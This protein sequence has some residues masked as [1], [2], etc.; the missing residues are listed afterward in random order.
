VAN[1]GLV[2]VPVEV[3]V[4]VADQGFPGM[5]V[6]GLASKAVEESRERVKTAIVNSGM[7]FPPKKITVNLAPADLPKDGAAYDLPIA[8]GILAAS[9]QI[10]D[11]QLEVLKKSLFYGELSLEGTLRSTKGVLL[12]GLYATT[13]PL[14][15]SPVSGEGGFD[16]ERKRLKTEIYV[17]IE[18]AN[19]AAVVEGISVFPVRNLKELMD[20]LSG[21][22]MI[23]PLKYIDSEKVISDASAEFDLSEVAGQEMA[24][25]ALT[26]AAAGGHNLIMWGPPGT[27]KTMLARAMPGILPPLLP[28]EALEVTRVYSVAGLLES[29][30]SLIRRRPFRSPHHGVSAAGM[31]G[32]GSN[33]LPG[34]V[35][36]AHLGV[37]FLDE[38]AEFPRGVLESL[39]QPME[40]GEVEIVRASAHVSYPASFTLVAAVNPCPCGYLGHPRREC[41]CG[42]KQIRKY[43]AKM[44]GPIL[45][46]IDLHVQ[47]PAVEVGKLEQ[48]SRAAGEQ[49]TSVA[50]R[51]RVMNARK[52][53]GERFKDAGIYTN[54]QMK[55]R[56][57]KQFCRLDGDSERL[58]RLA[59]EKYDLS[60]RAYFRLIKVARTIADLEGSE[61]I[62]VSHMAE[63]LQ[64]RQ[65]G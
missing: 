2:S 47:V 34:E 49:E 13:S 15:P 44:S 43:R 30:E 28:M 65:V 41:K 52:I 10:P 16:G 18:S 4:D 24:K 22:K 8:V 3:E 56:Q 45:D 39:R 51:E 46:R 33:P 58:L 6:V 12:V 54:S 37:L 14:R 31:I 61:D 63:A 50:V 42:E 38:M 5:T 11:F 1:V 7:D 17:P 20:H 21:V 19:E 27:G 32:G 25:R 23:D 62:G 9:Q 36:L 53:Q 40:D 57:I 60:A 35:S 48:E 59:T 29:G 64:Y 26:I 55:N